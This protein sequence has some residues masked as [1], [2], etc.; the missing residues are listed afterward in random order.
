MPLSGAG[1]GRRLCSLLDRMGRYDVSPLLELARRHQ[2]WPVQRRDGTR[3]M[4]P[5]LEQE[6]RRGPG[7]TLKLE[8]RREVGP[9]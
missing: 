8:R 2:A 3:R 4:N 7:V 1:R 6:T 5:L 9:S